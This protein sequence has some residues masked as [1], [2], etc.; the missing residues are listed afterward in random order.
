M[1]Q[2]SNE[3]PGM[4]AVITD[5]ATWSRYLP[6]IGWRHGTGFCWF[7]SDDEVHADRWLA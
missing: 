7:L 1:T 4:V 3:F 5:N 2:T 6:G